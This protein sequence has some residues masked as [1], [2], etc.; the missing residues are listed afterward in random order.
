MKTMQ[1][2]K[3]KIGSGQIIRLGAA[4]PA[5]TGENKSQKKHVFRDKF[6]TIAVAKTQRDQV[7]QEKAI[8]AIINNLNVWGGKFKND[9]VTTIFPV[10]TGERTN[11]VRFE[12]KKITADKATVL[13]RYVKPGEKDDPITAEEKNVIYDVLQAFKK[14]ISDIHCV[15]EVKVNDFNTKIPVSSKPA[16]SEVASEE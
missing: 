4:A 2:R 11:L 15:C 12:V 5:N 9:K 10:N 7:T 13:L 8:N 1:T 16:D 6:T 14:Y 3:K